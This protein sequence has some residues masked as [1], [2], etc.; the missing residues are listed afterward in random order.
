MP[1]I[2][3][4][5]SLSEKLALTLEASIRE[6]KLKLTTD[7]SVDAVLKVVE[8]RRALEAES[9]ALTELPSFGSCQTVK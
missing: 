2:Q 4:G 6:G 8:V 1:R 7:S 5:V 3:L 9:A